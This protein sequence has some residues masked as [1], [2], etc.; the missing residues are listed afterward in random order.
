[1]LPARQAQMI[2]EP[3]A[4]TF[5]ALLVS[6]DLS[7]VASAKAGCPRATRPNQI[8]S[9]PAS[10]AFAMR[11]HAREGDPG[12]AGRKPKPI[13]PRLRGRARA[14]AAPEVAPQRAP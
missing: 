8:L 3:R 7:A 2:N 1:M 5:M 11:R 4:H 10:I 9:S 13:L 12:D 14:H 6:A